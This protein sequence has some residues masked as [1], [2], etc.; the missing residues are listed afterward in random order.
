MNHSSTPIP[1]FSSLRNRFQLVL[2]LTTLAI[3]LQFFLSSRRAM[4][5]R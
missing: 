4:A 3:G 2:F 5:A 1:F